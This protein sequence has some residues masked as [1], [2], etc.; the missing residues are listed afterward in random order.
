MNLSMI[1]LEIDGL[2]AQTVENCV[3]HMKWHTMEGLIA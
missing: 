1:D 3:V 2:N